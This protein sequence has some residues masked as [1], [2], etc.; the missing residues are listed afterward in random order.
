MGHR[1][2]VAPVQNDKLFRIASQQVRYILGTHRPKP[3]TTINCEGVLVYRTGVIAC[4]VGG[5]TTI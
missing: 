3:G 4:R 1:I 5:K 2:T